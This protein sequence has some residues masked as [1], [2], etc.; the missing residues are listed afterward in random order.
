MDGF[1][2]GCAHCRQSVYPG[3]FRSRLTCGKIRIMYATSCCPVLRWWLEPIISH[4]QPPRAVIFR[5]EVAHY[6]ERHR[7]QKVSL[8]R[9]HGF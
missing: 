3:R 1:D 7:P 6:A 9:Q 5:D 2:A 8:E 4:K